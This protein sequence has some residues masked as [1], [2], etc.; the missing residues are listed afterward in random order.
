MTTQ[1]PPLLSIADLTAIKQIID[2][3]CSRGAFRAS[4]VKA[5]GE[6]FEKLDAFL[7]AVTEQALRDREKESTNAD[8]LGESQGESND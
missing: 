6:A 4:E 1:N 5:V 3:A 8:E 2:L 7:T